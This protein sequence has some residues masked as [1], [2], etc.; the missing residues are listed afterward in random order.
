MDPTAAWQT[1]VTGMQALACDPTDVHTREE[2]IW[3][4]QGLATW[5]D[6]GG[7][8]PAPRH[9]TARHR[10]RPARRLHRAW[11]IPGT[12]SPTP[13]RRPLGDPGLPCGCPSLL[14]EGAS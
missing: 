10:R 2:V 8:P 6:R 12:L 4:L 9:A 7:A 14:M 11:T 13:L 5:L 1:I 3:A